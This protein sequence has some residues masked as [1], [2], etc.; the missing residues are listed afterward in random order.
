M[1][2]IST[3]IS[4]LRHQPAKFRFPL[5]LG[6]DLGWLKNFFGGNQGLFCNL[7][8]VELVGITA[9]NSVWITGRN[10]VKVE[11]PGLIPKVGQLAYL[12]PSLPNHLHERVS[13]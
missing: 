1:R 8:S 13:Q 12:F 9:G 7:H 11:L 5:L 10:I 4:F 2:G 3:I 6:N